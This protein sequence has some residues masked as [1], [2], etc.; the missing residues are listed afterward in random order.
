LTNAHPFFV[1]AVKFCIVRIL[2]LVTYP[3]ISSYSGPS[4]IV[5]EMLR[6]LG[7]EVVELSCSGFGVSSCPAVEYRYGKT[8]VSE[9][10]KERI[11]NQCRSM[12][13]ALKNGRNESVIQIDEF[14]ES[15]EYSHCI[16]RAKSLVAKPKV[17][18]TPEE[19]KLIS[20]ASYEILLR[21]KFKNGVVPESHFQ[22]LEN[23][24][25]VC[26]LAQIAIKRFLTH[27]Y[28]FDRII[29]NNGLRG[30][31][32]TIL[33][34][35]IEDGVK[36]I[37]INAGANIAHQLSQIMIFNSEESSLDWASSPGWQEL[38]SSDAEIPRLQLIKDHFGS[39]FAAKSNFVYSVSSRRLSSD[40]IHK[41][42][43]LS[44]DKTTFL[45]TLA[46][47]DERMTAKSVGALEFLDVRTSLFDSQIEWIKFLIKEF[48][49]RPN[50]QLIIRVHP[51]EFPNK[52]E[53]V[54]SQHAIELLR[55]LNDLPTN[56]HVN[57]PSDEISLYDL[58]QVIDIGLVA[59]ST[60]GLQLA[61]LGIPIG[62]HNTSLLTGYT[63]DIGTALD[64]TSKYRAFLDSAEDLQWSVGNVITGLKWHSY[65]FNCLSIDLF[66]IA[67]GQ[68]EF[69]G[70][71]GLLNQLQVSIRKFM[72]SNF[73]KMI[74]SS[75]NLRP[76]IDLID[77][78]KIRA[79]SKEINV[80]DVDIERLNAL[81]DNRSIDLAADGTMSR[82]IGDS[83]SS[84]D[85]ANEFLY[86]VRELLPKESGTRFL[87]GKI[88]RY[89]N[90]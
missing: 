69:A 42:L 19:L 13:H 51:R 20:Y 31:N 56:V 2:N 16:L 28:K 52:R 53:S 41:K 83:G 37:Y 21:H 18:L 74:W 64:S 11:C 26:M 62:L 9:K 4:K 46:S 22:E 50:L 47:N 82:L 71:Y 78:S 73:K 76:L 75:N 85:S 57:W 32:R 63:T 29:I 72:P 8:I 89:L 67:D 12:S 10:E 84:I 54:T 6:G 34:C 55:E 35:L 30:L 36:P 66:P 25:Y 60:T 24:V 68:K 40:A 49:V 70:R 58:V 1:D 81:L 90:S 33:N 88:E 15:Y 79:D 80:S 86:F 3:I 14:I 23:A 17:T 27:N 43:S 87:S 45:A 39:L 7:H 48:Q 77:R 59:T 61:T 65:L 38:K 44:G 5:G